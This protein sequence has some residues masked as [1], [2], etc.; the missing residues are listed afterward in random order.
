MRRKPSQVGQGM[1]V[2]VVE[3]DYFKQHVPE[4]QLGADGAAL[5]WP[6][7]IDEA[8]HVALKQATRGM[9][10]GDQVRTRILDG[11]CRFG[12]DD[13][14]H[15]RRQSADWSERTGA[16]LCATTSVCGVLLAVLERAQMEWLSCHV[17]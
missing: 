10:A 16:S 1:A 2:A 6:K 17:P 3:R 7:E 9:S 13:E 14:F 8:T 5:S 11:N 12:F 15:P 4:Y